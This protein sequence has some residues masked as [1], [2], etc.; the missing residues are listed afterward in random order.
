MNADQLW[1]TTLNPETRTLI[2]LISM[3]RYRGD[4]S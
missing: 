4:A 2:G 1:E 3:I